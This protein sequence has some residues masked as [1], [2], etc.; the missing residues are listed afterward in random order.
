MPIFPSILHDRQEFYSATIG[1]T[2]REVSSSTRGKS[3]DFVRRPF[4]RLPTVPDSTRCTRIYDLVSQY[5]SHV[6]YRG[7]QMTAHGGLGQIGP[8]IDEAKLQAWLEEMAKRFG[9]AAI[10]LLSDFEGQDRRLDLTRNHYL[11]VTNAWGRKYYG[12]SFP[13]G[14]GQAAP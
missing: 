10:C 11:E 5:A 2:K 13:Q 1:R 8:F 14:R 9:H 7:F 4:P 3:G 6:T 12:P